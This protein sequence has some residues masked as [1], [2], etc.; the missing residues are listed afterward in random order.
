MKVRPCRVEAFGSNFVDPYFGPY[1]TKKSNILGI[2][3]FHYQLQ[4]HQFLSKSEMVM[5]DF[6]LKLVELAWNDPILKV[7]CYNSQLIV[8]ILPET[9]K[10][11]IVT[12]SSTIVQI[13][14][15]R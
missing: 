9:M 12:L 5:S 4:T 2:F 14:D 3:F 8:Y 7:K 11:L 13:H 6:I 10:P 1:W 15:E